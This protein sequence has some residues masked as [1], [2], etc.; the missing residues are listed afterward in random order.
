MSNY[1]KH[2]GIKGQKWGVRRFQN[3]DGSLTAKGKKRYNDDEYD[4]EREALEKENARRAGVKYVRKTKKEREEEDA[5]NERIFNARLEK[6]TAAQK[7]TEDRMKEIDRKLQAKYDLSS[8]E[9]LDKYYKEY[10]EAW[11]D[12]L[13]EERKKEGLAHA[14]LF[15]L[16]ELYHHGIKG[17]KW[18][19]R[20]YQNKD[21]S[22][23]PAGRERYGSK[24]NFD[25]QYP[26]DVKKS[27]NKAKGGL[28]KA[29]SAVDKAKDFNAKQVKK[30]QEEQIKK[31]VSKMSDQELKKI[32]N[33]LNMEER[34]K[35]VM[36]SR[37][38]ENGKNNVGKVLEYAGTALAVGVGAMELM[39]KIQE[40]KNKK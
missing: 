26:E 33:R 25:K 21:G 1:I 18:G 36:N 10:D 13:A 15:T 7:R 35:Q 19:R 29:S 30:A 5:E 34:Y 27:I 32:V 38:A 17:Q 23:T 2:H 40:M 12:I 8:M 31:D 28:N 22:L 24:D 14:D 4:E 20:Q 16:D 3:K 9:D 6:D 11:F 37:A 39:L